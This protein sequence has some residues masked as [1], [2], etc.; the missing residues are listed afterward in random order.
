MLRIISRLSVAGSWSPAWCPSCYVQLRST[1][2]PKRWAV[3]QVRY[4][5]SASFPVFNR[6]LFISLTAPYPLQSYKKN[7]SKT[8]IFLTKLV[9]LLTLTLPAA[10]LRWM[11]W[12]QLQMVL[13]ILNNF[14]M[15]NSCCSIFTRVMG[16]DA[17]ARFFFNTQYSQYAVRNVWIRA[18]TGI[19]LIYQRCY[20]LAGW[21]TECVQRPQPVETSTSAPRRLPTLSAVKQRSVFAGKWLEHPLLF[22]NF[23]PACS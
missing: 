8:S 5:C 16:R 2:S 6:K 1:L 3:F 13:G 19:A 17:R 20:A 21:R 18:L 14:I 22:W 7:C 11:S 23:F 4:L 12:Q 10:F 15:V 9:V